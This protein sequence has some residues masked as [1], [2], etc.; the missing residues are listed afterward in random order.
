MDLI[1]SS[2]PRGLAALMPLAEARDFAEVNRETDAY[3]HSRSVD[4]RLAHMEELRFLN[5]GDEAARP[6]Q[7]VLEVVQRTPR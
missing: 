6:L 5:Y 7:R 1:D 4:E 3:W 2:A